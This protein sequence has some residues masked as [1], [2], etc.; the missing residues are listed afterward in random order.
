MCVVIGKKDKPVRLGLPGSYVQSLDWVSTKSVVLYDA[1][2]RRAWLV[3]GASAVLHLVRASFRASFRKAATDKVNPHLL[4]KPNEL[5]EANPIHTGKE[6]AMSVLTDIRNMGLKVYVKTSEVWEETTDVNGIQQT[7]TKKKETYIRFQDHVERIYHALEQCFDLQAQAKSEDGYGLR[8]NPRRHLTGFDFMD[9]AIGAGLISPRGI[10]LRDTG[11][12][13]VDFIRAI[14]AVTLFGSGLGEIFQPT[15]PGI[16]PSWARLPLAKDYLAITV[17]EIQTILKKRGSHI[18]SICRLVDNLYWHT[19]EAAFE[20]CHCVQA[21]SLESKS[22]SFSTM[23]EKSLLSSFKGHISSTARMTFKKTER[24]SD[25]V[26]ILFSSQFSTLH[27]NGRFR[28]P[29][30]SNLEEHAGGALI[31]GH[32]W[33]FLLGWG[34][35]GEPQEAKKDLSSSPVLE[36]V[37]VVS[38]SGI[39]SSLGSSAFIDENGSRDSALTRDQP[40]PEVERSSLPS[41]SPGASTGCGELFGRGPVS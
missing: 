1:K 40:S 36:K 9:V 4:F 37:E 11:K 12:G 15:G 25:R 31:F 17:S 22:Q 39:G 27:W 30:E 7:I 8:M 33:K 18:D 41:T 10:T 6:A 2:D 5:V 20:E 3:D 14:D 24:H 29:T 28:S 35:D 32:S 16:C 13:W 21:S 19:P 34:D 26:Q 38:D 23:P